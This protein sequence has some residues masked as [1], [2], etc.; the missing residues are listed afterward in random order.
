[1]KKFI[2]KLHRS[3]PPLR[4]FMKKGAELVRRASVIGKCVETTKAGNEDIAG[5]VQDTMK[6]QT[7]VPEIMD[8]EIRL[9][10]GR[11]VERIILGCIY[12]M[13]F[14]VPIF[15]LT[16][17]FEVL[18]FN[19]QM[20]MVVFGLVA[21]L[22][23]LWKMLLQRRVGWVRNPLN[24]V[25]LVFLLIYLAIS[26]FSLHPYESFVGSFQQSAESFASVFFY[27]A[28]YF[29]ILNNVKSAY[30]LKNL[31]FTFLISGALAMIYGITQMNLGKFFP[32]VDSS[33]N[34]IGTLKTLSIFAAAL[35]PFAYSSVLGISILGEKER[36][37]RIN[38]VLALIFT[39]IALVLLIFVDYWMVWA[40]LL[41]VSVFILVFAILRAVNINPR[42]MMFPMA[43][44]IVAILFLIIKTPFALDLPVEVMPSHNASWNIT[45]S[46][47]YEDPLTGSGPGTFIFDYAKYR[48]PE[49]NQTQFWDVRFNSG[50]SD[51]MTRIATGGVLGL[52]SWL[53]VMMFYMFI[54]LTSLYKKKISFNWALGLGFFCSWFVIF[55]TRFIYTSNITLDFT[56]WMLMA[57]TMVAFNIST[58]KEPKAMLREERSMREARLSMDSS[59]RVALA[60][61]FAFVLILIG[62]VSLLYLE[63]QRLAADIY[64][65]KALDS[66][67]SGAPLAKTAE[68]LDKAAKLNRFQ[69]VFF[70]NLSQAFIL[71]F[72]NDA[73]MGNMT[74][75][76]ASLQL[77]INGAVENGKRATELSPNNV[78]NWSTLGYVY[79]TLMPYVGGSADWAVRSYEEAIK[80]EPNNPY[81]HTEL[82]KVYLSMSDSAAVAAE[83]END[84]GK[85]SAK[86]KE[87][88]ELLDKAYAELKKAIELKGDYAS[89]IFYMAIAHARKGEIKEAVANL[90]MTRDFNPMDVGVGLQLGIL[91]Y[92]DGQ[93]EK[94]KKELERV[95]TIMPTYSNARWYLGAIYEEEGNFAKAIEQIE[96]VEALNPANANVKNK[97]NELRAG[98]APKEPELPQPVKEEVEG[99]DEANINEPVAPAPEEAKPASTEQ[100]NS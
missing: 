22:F 95:V 79:E 75:Q 24:V 1:M 80:L 36:N 89:G 6:E 72:T 67:S 57:F 64:Y 82:G 11:V 13:V 98:I 74:D 90:E 99:E 84:E 100:P 3:K 88:D 12:A 61:H 35:I 60:F 4:A 30:H 83:G 69:D 93:K 92:Q 43:V 58:V 54:S 86:A 71:K 56:L 85:K 40:A 28:L 45:K 39:V 59:P 27:I 32:G 96:A 97:L 47:L 81:L 91:Y 49:I 77:V 94:A 31:I 15:F 9:K 52:L 66:N 50:S 20:V 17:T 7:V 53:A 33:F 44:L 8:R 18:E 51:I 73:A 16:S 46:A 63:G 55:I 76:L 37:L 25:I 19:K 41:A 5:Y 2:E 34:T 29:L 78:A 26:F 62:S 38:K 48:A 21:L 42:W 70:R 23:W 65:K 14:L 87:A 68:Y 10:A